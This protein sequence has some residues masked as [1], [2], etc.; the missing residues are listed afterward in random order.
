MAG[1]TI[2]IVIDAVADGAEAAV[3]KVGD[4]F[5]KLKKNTDHTT[6]DGK[7]ISFFERL[8]GAAKDSARGGLGPLGDA[9]D[10]LGADLD[11]MSTK[12]LVAGA[13]VAAL[14][15]AAIAS[16]NQFQQLAG[17]VRDFSLT[18]GVTAEEASR[19]VANMDDLGIASDS[20]AA[21]IGKLARNVDAGKLAEYGIEIARTSDGSVDMAATLGRVAD[22]LAV[23]TDPTKRATMGNDLL[24]RSYADLLPLLEQGSAGMEEFAASVSK[25]QV[26]SEEDLQAAR[27]LTFA[28]DGLKESGSDVGLTFAKETV[29]ALALMLNDLSEATGAVSG[30]SQGF[31]SFS[32][33][34]A[35][36]IPVIGQVFSLYSERADRAKKSTGDLETA[37]EKLARQ[38]DEAKAA[39]EAHKEAVDREADAMR[40]AARMA[41]AQR[42]ALDDLKKQQDDMISAT[43]DFADAQMAE[44]KSSQD[45]RKAYDELA[46]GTGEYGD[47]VADAMNA[48]Q[49]YVEKAWG[50]YEVQGAIAGKTFDAADKADF[51][52]QKLGDMI[53]ETGD[54]NVRDRLMSLAQ[55][56]SGVK[57]KTDDAAG[58]LE[59]FRRQVELIGLQD[60]VG[61]FAELGLDAPAEITGSTTRN[62]DGGNVR[63]GVPTLV[64]ESGPEMFVPQS[65]GR[66]LSADDLARV[67]GTG[68]QGVTINVMTPIGRPDDVVRWMREELRRLDRGQR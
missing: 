35:S 55:L 39:A 27:D 18:A 49:D 12:G 10:A 28:M 58:R 11:G 23:T 68:G 67:G 66:I 21:A 6:G 54:P 53:K 64:G 25:A 32:D 56:M 26:L 29:P 16:I 13:A 50:L 22:A 2:R 36:G 45:L 15:T 61:S 34:V 30:A 14:G 63:G 41:D 7:P 48:S 52:I 40:L 5:D 65:N 3:R 60:L 31:L 59:A 20:G 8:G 17:R 47:R 24:G 33:I 1:P 4:S 42:K 19:L 37:A 43:L 44:W 46:N 57:D 62:A 51:F 9:A 38:Q